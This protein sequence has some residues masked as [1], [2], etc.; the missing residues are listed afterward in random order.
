MEIDDVPL[1]RP[2]IAIFVR[3]APEWAVIP[4]HPTRFETMPD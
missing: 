4:A 1:F 2:T 3:D